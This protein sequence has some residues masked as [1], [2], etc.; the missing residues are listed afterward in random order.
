M[1]DAIVR[2]EPRVE[3]FLAAVAKEAPEG[4]AEEHFFELVESGRNLK[5]LARHFGCDVT[6]IQAWLNTDRQRLRGRLR[7]ARKAS[8][9]IVVEDAEEILD[10]LTEHREV[11]VVTRSGE[12]VTVM[13]PPSSSE[14]Q[15]ATSRANFKKWLAGV[16]D[17]QFADRPAQVNVGVSFGSAFLEALRAEGHRR[18]A[19]AQVVDAEIVEDE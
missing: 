13:Q 1:G 11:E 12:V 4:S 15:A 17:E 7:E 14:V 6:A 2:Y 3:R 19:E 16:Y 5:W 18:D 10:K 8:A 9:E